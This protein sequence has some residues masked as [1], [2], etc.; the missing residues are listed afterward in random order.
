MTRRGMGHY[1]GSMRN[2]NRV[3]PFLLRYF[4]TYLLLGPLHLAWA[5]QSFLAE[6]LTTDQGLSD[7]SVNCA[8]RDSYGLLWIGTDNGL[9]CY[10]GKHIHIY[11]DMV[12]SNPNE[13]NIILSLYEHDGNIWFGGNAGL[14]VFDR[15]QNT[16]HRFVER[17]RYGVMISS[18]VSKMVS[19][20][21]QRLVWIATM[22]QGIFIYDTQTR[23]LTQD[24]RHGSFFCD[25]FIGDNGLVYAVTLSGQLSVFRSDGHHLSSCEV[26]GYLSNK[27]PISIV[28]TG[29]ELWMAY[30]TRLLSLSSSL[31]STDMQ[32]DLPEA[33]SIHA[34]TADQSGRL[35][36]G[37]DNGIYRYT[38]RHQQ[39]ER[40]DNT[41]NQAE[42]QL[43]DNM[44][45]NFVWDRDS[46]L[47]ILTHSGGLNS[48]IVQQ[49]G[50]TFEAL[51]DNGHFQ[52]NTVRSICQAADGDLWIGTDHGL[53]LSSHEHTPIVRYGLGGIHY[54]INSLMLDGDHL[55]IGTR[56]DGIR[57]LNIRT[58][59]IQTKVFSDTQPYTIPSNEVNNIYRTSDGD[60]YVLTSWG[61]SR[62]SREA[63]HF[64][65]YASISAMT[66]FTSMAEA[67]GGWLWASSKTRGLFRKLPSE[68]SF[69]AFHSETIGRESVNI[70]FSDR[71]GVLW[72]ATNSGG[73]YRYEPKESDFARYDAEGTILHNQAVK[74]I[75]E[76]AQGALW[77]GTSSGIIRISPSRDIRDIRHYHFGRNDHFGRLQQS[78]C[79]LSDGHIVLGV[80][81]GIYRLAPQ[82]MRPIDQQQKVYIQRL[83]LTN[84]DDSKAEL[85]R[86]GLDVLLYTRR[87]IELPYADNSFTLHFSSTHYSGM[88][89][90]KYQYML[91]G[92]DR[93]WT[94]GSTTPEASYTNL[95]PG[96][97]VFHLRQL[98]H[99]DEALLRITVLP[100]W[101]RTSWAYAIYA[102]LAIAAMAYSYLLTRRRLK[103]RYERQMNEFK[104][105]QE[106]ETFQSKIRFFIDLVHE[107]RTPLTLMS[108]PLEQLED[109]Q[110]TS[111]IRRNMNYLLGIT[112]Q[113]LDFQKE[114]N[115]GIVLQLRQADV[116]DM[117]H[118]VYDQFRD[119]AEVQGKLL[120]L[121]IP[122]QATY[123]VID[124]EKMTKV[125]MNLVGNAMKY[126]K[127][128]IIIRLQ[129][130][131]DEHLRIEVIDDGHGVPKEERDKIF[132]RYYQIG[133]DHTAA[134]IGTGL[135]LA[136][137]K[138]L[139]QRH[140]GNLCYEEAPG[141]G[142][143]FAITI[144]IRSA[145]PEAS[146]QAI[147]ADTSTTAPTDTEDTRQTNVTY[148]I[149][150]VEDNQEL[151]S[152]TAQALREWYKVLMA[153]DGTEALEVLRY[154]DPDVVVS[155]IMMPRMDGIQ[156]CKRLKEDLETSHLPV[157]LL[158]AKVSVDAKVEGM[159]S[160][161]DIYL[162]KPFSI[163]QLHLQIENMLRLRQQFYQRMR[164]ID[165]FQEVGTSQDDKPMGINQQDMLFISNLQKSVK[166]HL[167]DEDFSIDAL[168][169]QLHLSRSSFYR[170]IK[171]LTG[172]SPNDY[173]K[174]ARLN[175]AARLL[176]SG[177][178]SSEVALRV[179][180]TS[181][182]YFAKCFRAQF[183]CLPKEYVK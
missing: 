152:A 131:D 139:A 45:N 112:N 149:L 154:H 132:D 101:Y 17:T 178:R 54:E 95:P 31:K 138:M 174:T 96:E 103:Q 92:F 64:R 107:I 156:L 137:A 182:S 161:A 42:R 55:W 135:G 171:A 110:H 21:D 167:D 52:D 68:E 91:E 86:L 82:L 114:E 121:Q 173:L 140:K 168:A 38:P 59:E 66:S 34:L 146:S 78:S 126:A 109:N 98:G 176:Q 102:L 148:T 179:G 90:V 113:L 44:V 177:L 73:L 18:A 19:T 67:A 162:E 26:G 79:I 133:H 85:R 36:L 5:Q 48:L 166:D 115:G 47:L 49:L 97:Y 181:S 99:T 183:G 61:L 28:M 123:A 128:Q 9:N 37:T 143:C 125:M 4:W 116:N 170:K 80:R 127:S 63:G 40:I 11:R 41:D 164:S 94:H 136:Y 165:G 74:F 93:T 87:Q 12:V 70:L 14:Y 147:Q 16:S 10:D 22:G 100:P 15:H 7:N 57:I 60:I 175:E 142:S 25:I 8:L 72:A 43:T 130:T 119:A 30:N 46:T 65:S 6:Q 153:H 69:Y 83:S 134:N 105:R 129:Q 159:E 84:A 150:L 106:K 104:Q 81:K 32:F 39:M 111:A 172:M 117:L 58:G 13:T 120:Q 122:E 108:L 89:D 155:D 20:A 180:F 145:E 3:C 163:R 23:Q 151:L 169:E 29:G 27:N 75:Q 24:S 77:L 33:G 53:Y 76:D 157:I 118:M 144:P 160:G 2:M 124:R 50:I 141:G 71:K 56:H 62:Y 158:T 51:P 1:L 35:Y 88:P